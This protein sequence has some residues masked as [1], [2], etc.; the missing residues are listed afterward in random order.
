MEVSNIL[1]VKTE[2]ISDE[3]ITLVEVEFLKN[4]AMKTSFNMTREAVSPEEGSSVTVSDFKIKEE[5]YDELQKETENTVVK[6]EPSGDSTKDNIISKFSESDDE[7]DCS[8]H[9]VMSLKSEPKEEFQQINCELKVYQVSA[10]V[11]NYIH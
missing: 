11:N 8:Q 7:T 3:E 1:N 4:E 5:K 6:T 9:D 10:N 2:P